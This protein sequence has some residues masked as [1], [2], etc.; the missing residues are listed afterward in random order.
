MAIL[1]IQILELDN[2]THSPTL[3]SHSRPRILG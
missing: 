1:R 2:D 3:K